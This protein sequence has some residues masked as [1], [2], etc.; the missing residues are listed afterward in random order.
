MMEFKKWPRIENSYQDE[1]IARFVEECPWLE[2]APYIITEKIHGANMQVAFAPHQSYLVGSRK[3]WI[4]EAENFN[5]IR[6]ILARRQYAGLLTHL[7]WRAD[8]A[9]A[10]IR[11]FG[12]VFGRGIQ[13]KGVDYGPPRRIRFF[14]IMQD[15]LLVPPSAFREILQRYNDFSD[16]T[17]V[18]VMAYT[19]GLEAALAF[20]P[21][22]VTQLGPNDADNIMEGVVIQPE[23]RVAQSHTGKYFLLKHKNRAFLERVHT[24]KVRSPN[25]PLVT[26]LQ[27]DF[28]G[29]ICDMRIQAVFSK[30]GCIKE[31]TQL[32]EYIRLVLQDATEDFVLDHSDIWDGLD[33]K[34]RGQVT[35]RAGSKAAKILKEY[36]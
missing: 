10:Q 20:N 35:K 28:A 6:N 25:S 33:K 22:L 4:P 30:Y 1:F 3:R 29:Y 26:S 24:K 7:Q 27:E 23:H 19:R 13:K 8:D 12:E 17:V 2:N 16:T 18:P 31:I 14:G 9:D 21:H 5:N 15:E 34:S 11:L 36:L 32:G